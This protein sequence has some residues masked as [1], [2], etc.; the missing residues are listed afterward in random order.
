MPTLQRL[1]VRNPLP[2]SSLFRTYNPQPSPE[3]TR[4]VGLAPHLSSPGAPGVLFS[5][6]ARRSRDYRLRT[7]AFSLEESKKFSPTLED[8][9]V[10]EPDSRVDLSQ[11]TE[12]GQFYGAMFQSSDGEVSH[13]SSPPEHI[14]HA[15]GVTRPSGEIV[16]EFV[17]N[18]ALSPHSLQLPPPFSTSSRSGS[19]NGSLPVG[20]SDS[21]GN[22]PKIIE[23]GIAG[24]H[25]TPSSGLATSDNIP[26]GQGVYQSPRVSDVRTVH[27]FEN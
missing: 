4:G 11:P 22:S 23:R 9:A 14:F 20:V 16:S 24:G 27:Q 3:R 12:R 25:S 15:S 26:E 5:Q 21:T 10:S 7:S 1:R 17:T 18:S 2:R 19:A 6:P 8:F 13:P